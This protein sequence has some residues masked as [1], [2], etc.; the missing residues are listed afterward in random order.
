[1]LPP[2]ATT[3]AGVDESNWKAACA[4][5][6]SFCRWHIAPSHRETVTVDG[7]GGDV[8]F[9]PTHRLTE[10]HSI[11]DDGR[12]VSDPEWSAAGMVRG[13][14]S[15]KFRGVVVDMTHGLD[16][17]PDDVL[18]VALSLAK[19]PPNGGLKS[20]GAGPFSETYGDSDMSDSERT[21]LAPYRM[22]G[23]P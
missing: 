7:S 21:T 18:N 9:L 16:E 20:K 15:C 22:I 3:P 10:I 19:R 2:L 8:L 1:M 4:A 11:V 14:W 12:E 13:S 17:C 23:L 6:R 5:V